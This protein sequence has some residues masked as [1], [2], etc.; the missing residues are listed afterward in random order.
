MNEKR[1]ND[2]EIRE[3]QLVR[4]RVIFDQTAEHFQRPQRA[5]IQYPEYARKMRPLRRERILNFS[6][7]AEE[8]DSHSSETN[9]QKIMLEPG[10]RY[11]FR[12][13]LLASNH[14][15]FPNAMVLALEKHTVS[16]YETITDTHGSYL[17]EDGTP[18]RGA[19]HPTSHSGREE[20][21][22]LFEL[23]NQVLD[24]DRQIE[25]LEVK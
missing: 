15:R 9:P 6:F 19:D 10:S 7:D 12:I 8:G 25:D 11:A 3:V 2:Q 23:A 4:G 20:I 5:T 16:D 24:S 21:L 14:Q 18:R 22:S 17:L 1:I 13:R